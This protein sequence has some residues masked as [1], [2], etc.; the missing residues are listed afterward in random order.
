VVDLALGMHCFAGKMPAKATPHAV[1]GILPTTYT[2]TISPHIN[3]ISIAIDFLQAR[4]L[5]GLG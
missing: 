3:N 5:Q 2:L 1:V 4:C